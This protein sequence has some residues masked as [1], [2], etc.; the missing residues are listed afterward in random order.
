MATLTLDECNK[1]Q[2]FLDNLTENIKR[3]GQMGNLDY[4]E[5]N[6]PVLLK[7]TKEF[8]DS[9]CSSV[10]SKSKSLFVD[11]T[12]DKYTNLDAQRIEAESKYQA[13]KKIFIGTSV[14]LI[15][16]TLILVLKSK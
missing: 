9:E 1:K 11:T 12:I 6:T 4:V 15:G 10:I 8:N 5:A 16:I 2:W 14:L 7:Y 13:N 3:Y